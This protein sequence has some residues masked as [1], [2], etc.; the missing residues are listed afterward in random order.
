MAGFSTTNNEHLIRSEIWSNQIKKV[1]EDE[2][3]GTRYVKMITDF[4]DGDQLTI[5]SIGT[6]DSA[7]YAEGQAVRYTAM[8]TTELLAA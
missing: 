3:M 6:M 2:L 1:L 5:P 8:D 4:P 7:D